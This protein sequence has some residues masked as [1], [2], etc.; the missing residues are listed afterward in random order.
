[1]LKDLGDDTKWWVNP[2]TLLYPFTYSGQDFDEPHSHQ[3]FQKI[4]KLS[5]AEAT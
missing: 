1:M 3:I 2:Y 5:E 4:L